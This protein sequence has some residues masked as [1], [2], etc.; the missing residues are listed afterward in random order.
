MRRSNR[1]LLQGRVNGLVTPF[2]AGGELV[3]SVRNEMAISEG[4]ASWQSPSP[5][6]GFR[7]PHPLSL[8]KPSSVHDS[9]AQSIDFK[10]PLTPKKLDTS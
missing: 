10:Q 4:L 2:T 7:T 6:E 3:M 9:R 8:C 1:Q 5:T